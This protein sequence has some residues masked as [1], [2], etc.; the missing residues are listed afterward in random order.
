MI[1]NQKFDVFTVII[2]F[3]FHLVS[4]IKWESEWPDPSMLCFLF[5]SLVLLWRLD[6]QRK[7]IVN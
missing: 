2:C 3:V 1:Q 6:I 4:L 7:G 5:D